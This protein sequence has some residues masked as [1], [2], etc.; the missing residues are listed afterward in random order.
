MPFSTTVVVK[1]NV[2]IFL[3][4]VLSARSSTASRQLPHM[5]L[6]N[7]AIYIMI[8]IGSVA[9]ARLGTIMASLDPNKLGNSR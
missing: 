6:S 4:Q 8:Q 5:A 9:T 2:G 1:L 3:N 7:W